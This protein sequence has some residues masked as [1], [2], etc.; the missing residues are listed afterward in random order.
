MG[1]EKHESEDRPAK[2][3]DQLMRRYQEHVDANALIMFPI[4][5]FGF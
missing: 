4:A 5:F 2:T 3:L 1:K